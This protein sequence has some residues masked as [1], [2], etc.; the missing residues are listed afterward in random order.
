MEQRDAPLTVLKIGGAVLTERTSERPLLNRRHLRRIAR[1]IA[2][3]YDPQRFRLVIVHGA[4][5]FG[6][7]IVMRTGIHNG[8]RTAEQRVALART[9]MLQNHLDTLVVRAL[10]SR[11]I[12]AFPV[13]PS[14]SSIAAAGRLERIDLEAARG[15]LHWGLVPVFYGVPTYDRIRGCSILSG[16]RIAPYIGV[17]LGAST[18]LHGTNVRGVY[19]DDPHRNPRAEFI[20]RI[21]SRTID[22]LEHCL[23]SSSA[24]DVTGGMHTKVRELCEAGIPAQIFDALTP[25]NV[26]RAL[27]GE[28]VGTLVQP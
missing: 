17:C 28:I 2:A 23:K 10:I 25:G 11:G 9:Q 6:H 20:E 27:Q 13:Q 5:S 19:T 12:P 1:E 8:L 26:R 24:P 14:A 16:D 7:P 4:G 15:L 21:D 3:A 18:I 22:A